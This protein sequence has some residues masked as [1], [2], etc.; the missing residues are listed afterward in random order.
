[1]TDKRAFS[2]DEWLLLGDAPLAAAAAVALAEPGG[3]R[4]EAAAMLS[5]W[6]EAARQVATSELLRAIAFE[7]DPEERRQG[8]E[9]GAGGG[10][11]RDEA[12]DLCIRADEL[13]AQ[14]ATPTE[15]YEYA[16]FVMFIAER[17]ARADGP[18]T[19]FGGGDEQISRA[20]RAALREIA[21]ALRYRP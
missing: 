20:E 7:L 8:A 14:R 15:R 12:R 2:T 5:G 10:S 4:R 6:R 18:G 3:G 1:M 16:R 21:A 17:V 19:L 9:T 13:L 11:I